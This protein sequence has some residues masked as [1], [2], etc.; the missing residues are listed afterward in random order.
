MAT[1]PWSL[2]SSTTSPS[3]SLGSIPDS[4]PVL[5]RGRHRSPR[6]GACFMEMA[7]YLS[8]ERWSDHP[9]CT[10]A[11]L[12][13]TARSVNDHVTDEARAR[14]VPLIPDVIGLLPTSPRLDAE[15]AR[16]AAL[17]ALP[18]APAARQRVAAV[19]L[20]RCQQVLN[21]HDGLP[22]E[23]RDPRVAA[24]LDEVPAAR[25]WARR[26]S[27]IGEGGRDSFSRRGAPAIVHSSVVGIAQSTA[28]DPDG[29]LIGLLEQTIDRCRTQLARE[30][31]LVPAQAASASSAV[32]S[33]EGAVRLPVR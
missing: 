21:S 5:S 25:D 8:G 19:G 22:D 17:V 29:L 20:I 11:L 14:I 7:S 13:T 15:I 24:A 6:K 28:K 4:I 9:S 2:F 1:S 26:F 23:H 32:S 12:A 27:L 10:H 33:V 18:V 3:A 31:A 30:T 16:D